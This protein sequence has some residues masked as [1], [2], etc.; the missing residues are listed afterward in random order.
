M[1]LSNNL[2]FLTTVAAPMIRFSAVMAVAILLATACSV[3]LDMTTTVTDLDNITHD[4]EYSYPDL[5]SSAQED[6]FGA[7]DSRYCTKAEED[8]NI[9]V[10]CS[11]IPH[12]LLVQAIAAG[13]E[14]SIQINVTRKDLGGAVGISS[15]DG[16]PLHRSQ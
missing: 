16:Q 4:L 9:V 1:N 8:D 15:R 11:G 5:S 3:S 2:S 14:S 13:E 10:T 7:F 12:S 6:D